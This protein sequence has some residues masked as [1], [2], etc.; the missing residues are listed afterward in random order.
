MQHL[1]L[2]FLFVKIHTF[3]Q[4]TWIQ[5]NMIVKKQKEWTNERTREWWFLY[6]YIGIEKAMADD[7]QFSSGWLWF[8]LSLGFTVNYFSI[9]LSFETRCVLLQIR[10]LMSWNLTF[11]WT[12]RKNERRRRK[13]RDDPKEVSCCLYILNRLQHRHKSSI[14]G[15]STNEEYEREKRVFKWVTRVIEEDDDDD[16]SHRCWSTSTTL[17]TI[18]SW[19]IKKKRVR[20]ANTHIQWM[21][22]HTHTHTLWT[23]RIVACN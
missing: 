2:F 4:C 17:T 12:T 13:R 5:F 7:T 9:I 15:P 16:C 8:H 22:K 3:G 21:N 23:K 10:M 20:L 6:V 1:F 18:L 19:L 14:I 11:Q